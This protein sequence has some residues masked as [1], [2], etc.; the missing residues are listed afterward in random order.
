MFYSVLFLFGVA[1]IFT[2]GSSSAAAVNQTTNNTNVTATHTVTNTAT[3]TVK[4]VSTTNVN[5]T[6]KTNGVVVDNLTIAQLKNGIGRVEVFY[7]N[8]HR[9]PNYVSYGSRHVLIAAFQKDIASQGL[10]LVLPKV[11]T[12]PA[13]STL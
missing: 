6:N 1:L 11:A 4:P 12:S 3:T 2:V 5:C 9:L 10:K 7:T 13:P 8:N